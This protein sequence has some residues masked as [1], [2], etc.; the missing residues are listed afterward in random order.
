MPL[1]SGTEP[2]TGNSPTL[3]CF[4]FNQIEDGPR[5]V[6]HP[7]ALRRCPRPRARRSCR[8]AF[9]RDVAGARCR[10]FCEGGA[11]SSSAKAALR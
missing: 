4:V 9:G 1:T 11:R 2:I 7:A 5:G 8:T 10:E 3:E 6:R